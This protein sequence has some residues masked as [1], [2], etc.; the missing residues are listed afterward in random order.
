MT[1]KV[2]IIK[3]CLFCVHVIQTKT[4]PCFRERCTSSPLSSS[5]PL[6]SSS[7]ALCTSDD[8]STSIVKMSVMMA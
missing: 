3:Y 2:M 1:D 5:V 6:S 4:I 8:V 7:R